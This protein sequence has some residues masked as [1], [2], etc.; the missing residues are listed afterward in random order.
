VGGI[1]TVVISKAALIE[2]AYKNYFLIGPY[3]HEKAREELV[4]KE[5][6]MN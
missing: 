5:C 6:Q 4:E 2:E 3:F 1:Y